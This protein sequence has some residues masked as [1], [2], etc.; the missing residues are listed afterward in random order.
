MDGGRTRFWTRVLADERF[1]A[2]VIED[3]LR[4][5]SG[6]GDVEVSARQMRRLEEMTRDERVELVDEVVRE[7]F[8]KTAIARYGPMAVDGPPPRVPDDND[9]ENGR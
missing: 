4:A 9:D 6:A 7:A 5:V 8:L 2:A 1:R 3:P